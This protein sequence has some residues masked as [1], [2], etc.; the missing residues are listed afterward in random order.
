MV[1]V[2]GCWRAVA[3]PV[4]VVWPVFPGVGPA[5]ASC[6][7]DLPAVVLQGPA[8]AVP[9]L[10][11]NTAQLARMSCFVFICGSL[12]FALNEIAPSTHLEV[13][14]QPNRRA[15]VPGHNRTTHAT[16]ESMP[17]CPGNREI[18]HGE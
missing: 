1:L 11:A 6:C 4:V 8:C 18:G 3:E 10:K 15:M 17:R 13:D 12:V 9:T 2:G 16:I 7:A 5:P 14:E